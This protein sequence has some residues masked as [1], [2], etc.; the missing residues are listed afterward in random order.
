MKQEV[1]VLETDNYS[2]RREK[3][4]S[5]EKDNVSSWLLTVS[6]LFSLV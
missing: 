5:K 2:N 6:E 3:L 4:A 1:I